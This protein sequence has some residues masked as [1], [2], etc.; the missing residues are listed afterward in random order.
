M[1]KTGTYNEDGDKWCC[2]CKTYHQTWMFGIN[3]SAKDGL[4]YMC[5][6][7]RRKHI[8]SNHEEKL[9]MA[10]RV[11]RD[12]MVV[13][14]NVQRDLLRLQMPDLKLTKPYEYT[15]PD[16]YDNYMESLKRC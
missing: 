3:R 8:T 14:I 2:N 7:S 10:E 9:I 13:R 1:R 11:K 6:Q 15:R 16:A 12:E 5:E 4:S